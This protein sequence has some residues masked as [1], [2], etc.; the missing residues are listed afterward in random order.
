M[1][2]YCVYKMATAVN[3]ALHRRRRLDPITRGLQMCA[4]LLDVDHVMNVEFWS[5]NISL[6][7]RSAASCWCCCSSTSWRSP[8]TRRPRPDDTHSIAKARAFFH[9]LSVEVL[10]LW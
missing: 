10:C 2:E 7:L 8:T 5:Q 9:Y 1:A 4:V 3:V 6:M